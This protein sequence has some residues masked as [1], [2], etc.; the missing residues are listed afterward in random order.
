MEVLPQ[1]PAT[2]PT[3]QHVW[4]LVGDEWGVG[5]TTTDRVARLDLL[6]EY[7]RREELRKS[8][9]KVYQVLAGEPPAVQATEERLALQ[10]PMLL[11][12]FQQV[13]KIL[14]GTAFAPSFCQNLESIGDDWRRLQ[15][16][17][18]VNEDTDANALV[19]HLRKTLN[20][21]SIEAGAR[22]RVH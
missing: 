4:L 7:A 12:V 16:L 6:F 8:L 11:T 5:E 15:V 1:F 9:M 3:L 13:F 2:P 21:L 22:L 14:A 10:E 17:T 19:F 18:M 20:E